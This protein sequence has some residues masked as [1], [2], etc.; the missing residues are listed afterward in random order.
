MKRLIIKASLATIILFSTSV[1]FAQPNGGGGGQGGGGTPP[2]ETGGP[3]DSGAVILLVGV[4]AYA[5][6]KLKKLCLLFLQR[7]LFYYG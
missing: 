6:Q 1:I 3:I 2:D 7:A 4:A 5:H